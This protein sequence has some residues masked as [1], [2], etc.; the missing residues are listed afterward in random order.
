MNSLTGSL[1]AVLIGAS[2]LSTSL[3][4]AANPF[5]QYD[6]DGRRLMAE[7]ATDQ[8]VMSFE[9]ALRINPFDPVALNNLAAAK[10]ESGDF[11]SALELLK[12]AARL[13]PQDTEIAANLSRL[14]GWLNSYSEAGMAAPG[15]QD[16]AQ[17]Q[18]GSLPPPP[19]PLWEPVRRR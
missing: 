14:R 11:H 18:S 3:P 19:P 1:G 7:G 6:Q 4:A 17:N 13:A 16:L 10:V 2:A 12:R 15:P 9:E 8:A 5:Q